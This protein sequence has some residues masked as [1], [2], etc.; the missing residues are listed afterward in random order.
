MELLLVRHALPLRVERDDGLPADPPLSEEGRRQAERL[1]RWLA[2]EPIDALYA[3]P[4]RR[5]L[6]TAQ[7]IAKSLGLEIQVEPGVTEFDSLSSVYIPLEELKALDYERWRELVGGGLIDGVDFPEFCRVS[8]ASLER[9]IAERG[10]NR[11]AVVCHGGIVNI[12]AAHVLGM[13]I[14][15]FFKPDYTSIS[16]FLAAGTGERSLASLNETA[17]LRDST[18]MAMRSG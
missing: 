7:P 11:V 14:S 1:A 15:L 4:L 9:I 10:G 16:R 13:E 17:H 12:W 3:S 8:I 18:S 5:A 2:S 6:E